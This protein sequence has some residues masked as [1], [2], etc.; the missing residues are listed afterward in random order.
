MLTSQQMAQ[1]AKAQE[2]ESLRKQHEAEVSHQYEQAQIGLRA[3]SL[4][5]EQQAFEHEVSMA[6]MKSAAQQQAARRISAGEDPTKVWS[7]LGPQLG[8]TGAGLANVLK[9]PFRFTGAQPVPGRTDL[10]AIQ[11]GP[12]QFRIMPKQA[13]VP[14]S[15]RSLPILGADGQPIRGV[16]GTPGPNGIPRIHNIPTMSDAEAAMEMIKLK[17]GKAGSESA[18]PTAAAAPA[19]PSLSAQKAQRANE[20]ANENPDWTREEIIDAVNEEFQQ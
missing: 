20:L 6:A 14:T 19:G 2:E 7:E 16:F 8:L 17:A 9:Q 5:Q 15:I 12:N 11:T 10:D 18:L 13:K 1:E 3:R 4:D